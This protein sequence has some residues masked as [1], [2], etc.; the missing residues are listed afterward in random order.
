M[1]Q[2]GSG[3]V[4]AVAKAVRQWVRLVSMPR[5]GAGPG[6]VRRS[7]LERADAAVRGGLALRAA[8]A[9]AGAGMAY[10]GIGS[11][12]VEHVPDRPSWACRVCARP[13]PCEPARVDMCAEMDLVALAA[14][15]W[16]NLEDAV[17]ELADLPAGE[18][19]DRFISWT[20]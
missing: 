12:M 19:F 3:L 18:L 8:V 11:M 6:A 15:M 4:Q 13:W 14:Y 20:R 16:L 10:A 7:R 1:P 17:L 9:D 2:A 5:L